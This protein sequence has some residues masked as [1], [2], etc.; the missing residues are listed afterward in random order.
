[1]EILIALSVLV[2]VGLLAMQFGVDSR[3]SEHDRPT[4]W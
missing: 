2:F 3:P 4:N 1:M